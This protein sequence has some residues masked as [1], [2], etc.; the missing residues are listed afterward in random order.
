M[1]F[2]MMEGTNQIVSSNL[3]EWSMKKKGEGWF[4]LTLLQLENKR[5]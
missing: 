3:Q 4:S 2:S 1:A 5:K